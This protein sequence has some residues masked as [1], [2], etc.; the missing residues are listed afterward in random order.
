[1]TGFERTVPSTSRRSTWIAVALAAA[2]F[3]TAWFFPLLWGGGLQN[4]DVAG[5]VYNARV[6]LN[7]GLPYLDTTEMKSPGAFFA[8]APTLALGGL[9]GMWLLAI[10]WATA[11][12]LATGLLVATCWGSRHAALAV[13]IHAAGAHAAGMG[14]ANYSFWMTLPFT[15]T[16]TAVLRRPSD[17]RSLWAAIGALA[18]AAL[19]FKHNALALALPLGLGI[20]RRAQG[21]AAR[22]LLVTLLYGAGGAGVVLGCFMAP[23]VFAGRAGALFHALGAQVHYTS[24]YVGDTGD[25]FGGPVA[26]FIEGLGCAIQYAP[27]LFVLAALGLLRT[28]HVP[29]PRGTWIGVASIAVS[30]LGALALTLRFFDH[31]LVMIWP[32]AVVL[33]LAPGGVPDRL[34][35]WIERSSIR[36]ATAATLGLLVTAASFSQAVAVRLYL[37][38]LDASV[39]KLCRIYSP[40]LSRDDAIFAWGWNA[41]SAYEHCRRFAPGPHY[42][43][44]GIVTTTNTNTCARP[45]GA[46]MR[47][48]PG[49]DL[50]A[51]ERELRAKPPALIMVAPYYREMHSH[52]PFED[53]QGAQALLRDE[54]EQVSAQF[55]FKIWLHRRVEARAQKV[56][57]SGG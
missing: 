15:L 45:F 39:A 41:W 54:Y 9:R 48:L 19:A 51:L 20:A 4:Q 23:Y 40:A 53:F 12:S 31:D 16:Q 17:S 32:V 43:E 36:A 44:L 49:A 1:M 52:D 50:D 33:A 35:G 28:R 27:G 37:L 42:K 13:L 34:F 6:L 7:G 25:N 56:V 57:D 24:S 26:L 10:V 11:T 5:I 14:D 38:D 3:H 18:C 55:G 2:L 46:P 8:I 47:L 29:L 30:A 21:S 22:E